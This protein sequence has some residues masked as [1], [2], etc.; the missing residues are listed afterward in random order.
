MCIN[1]VTV[2]LLR[3]TVNQS[4][5]YVNLPV[6]DCCVCLLLPVRYEDGGWGWK[7]REKRAEMTENMARYLIVTDSDKKPVGFVH[8]RFDMDYDEEVLY[9]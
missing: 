8:F 5:L 4:L 1:G 2:I 7:D 9:V 3:A 6:T